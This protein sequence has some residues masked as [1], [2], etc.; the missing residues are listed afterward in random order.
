MAAK[1]SGH[2]NLANQLVPLV[3]FL[4]EGTPYLADINHD[5]QVSAVGAKQVDLVCESMMHDQMYPSC[6]TSFLTSCSTYP[7][8]N[9]CVNLTQTEVQDRPNAWPCYTVTEQLGV[10]LGPT[11]GQLVV[12]LGSTWGQLGVDLCMLTLGKLCACRLTML[13][14]V[15]STVGSYNTTATMLLLHYCTHYYYS[16]YSTHYC[17][18]SSY[19][20]SR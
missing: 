6:K 14:N 18:Y 12:N 17:C 1:H 19:Y 15:L 8:Y 13:Q 10:N 9:T 3:V 5:I 2:H 4:P 7:E 16:S 11:W 20:N